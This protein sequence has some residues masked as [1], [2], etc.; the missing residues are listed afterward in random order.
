MPSGQNICECGYINWYDG[1]FKYNYIESGK[2]YDPFILKGHDTNGDPIVVLRP[3][4]RLDCQAK[5]NARLMEYEEYNNI[6]QYIPGK[7]GSKFPIEVY[8]ILL[9][10]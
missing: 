1:P 3:N 2:L 5:V 8:N 7:D 9:N 4:V 6:C 10:G